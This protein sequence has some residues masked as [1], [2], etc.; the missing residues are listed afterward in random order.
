MWVSSFHL[1]R[2]NG[3]WHWV[4]SDSLWPHGLLPSR[5]LRPWDFPGKNTGLDCYFLLQ[6]IFL[7]LGWNVG[8]NPHF[9]LVGRFF[10]AEPSGKPMVGLLLDLFQYW[11]SGN[12]EAQ[13]EG[14]KWGDNQWE[15][16]LERKLLSSLYL[17]WT[18]F[19]VSQN[20]YNKRSLITDYHNI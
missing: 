12:T 17:I 3:F 9:L 11:I 18:W 16:Q 8:L 13:G 5:L 7:T 19:V 15:E 2:T 20:D 6:G 4:M 10:T 1:K 14:E